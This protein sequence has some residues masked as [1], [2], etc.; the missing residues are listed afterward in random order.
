[1]AVKGF[2]RQA[3]AKRVLML[4]LVAADRVRGADPR[5]PVPGHVLVPGSGQVFGSA[6]VVTV[7]VEQIEIVD[8]ALEQF[9]RAR[10][11]ARRLGLEQQAAVILRP[12]I[13]EVVPGLRRQ[14]IGAGLTHKA[15]QVQPQA[16]VGDFGVFH[17]IEFGV[18]QHAQLAVGAN[19]QPVAIEQAHKMAHAHHPVV[20]AYRAAPGH[21]HILTA[22]HARQRADQRLPQRLRRG[23]GAGL[24]VERVDGAQPA[25]RGVIVQQHVLHRI[26]AGALQ[27]CEVFQDQGL[28]A[29][30]KV[31]MKVLMRVLMRIHSA[32]ARHSGG[33]QISAWKR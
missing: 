25:V 13:N 24:L 30:M 2:V 28:V 26:D 9:Q 15:D 23:R 29:L 33:A 22:L 17:P 12:G 19:A 32:V 7:Q 8:H 6:T 4:L 3:L 27:V 20:A 10:A 31:L 11:L 16:G 18:A 21:K 14:R 1:M 5:R